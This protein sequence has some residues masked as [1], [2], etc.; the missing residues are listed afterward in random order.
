MFFF[1]IYF[2][3]S[4]LYRLYKWHAYGDKLEEKRNKLEIKLS[5]LYFLK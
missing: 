4:L 1:L 5:S 3:K 2:I